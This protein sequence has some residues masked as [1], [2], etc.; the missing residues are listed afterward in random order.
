MKRKNLTQ[1]GAALAVALLV[2]APAAHAA[3]RSRLNRY[4]VR[5]GDTLAI[6]ARSHKT[7]ALYLARVNKLANPNMIRVGQALLVPAT[8]AQG[9]TGKSSTGAQGPAADVEDPRTGPD[10][11]NVQDGPQ[12]GNQVEDGLPDTGAGKE[13]AGPDTDN[14]QEG[15]QTSPD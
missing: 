8:G 4:T 12:D 6:I 3:T 2:G 11:D 1:A 5:R 7:T 14:I 10:T 15:D 9:T 13:G